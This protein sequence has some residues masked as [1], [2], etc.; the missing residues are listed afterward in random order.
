MPDNLEVAVT[1]ARAH[2]GRPGWRRSML[3]RRVPELGG[4]GWRR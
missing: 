1:G 2:L 4:G 3:G